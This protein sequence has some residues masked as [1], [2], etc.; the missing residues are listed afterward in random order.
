MANT[1]QY[2]DIFKTFQLTL[3]KTRNFSKESQDSIEWLHVMVRAVSKINNKG[4]IASPN[5]IMKS[6]SSKL[7]PAGSMTI[8]QMYF[9]VYD[10]KYKVE[11]PFY[12]NFPLVFPFAKR[13]DGKGFFAVNLH[14][15]HPTIRIEL[16]QKLLGHAKGHGM[17]GRLEWDYGV[18]K[19]VASHD[20]T[21]HCVKNYLFSQFKTPLFQVL[22]GDWPNAALLPVERFQK[23]RKQTVWSKM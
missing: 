8:G 12:D 22:P 5:K 15:L 20:L 6:D 21:K 10:P 17:R 18:L 14:Y 1:T 13:T 2:D 3:A 23:E 11:L 4:V 16:L 7:K 19:T 9:Y